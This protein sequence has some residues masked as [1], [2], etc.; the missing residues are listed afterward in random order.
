MSVRN[1]F[2]FDL[3]EP[4]VIPLIDDPPIGL[5]GLDIGAE[6][7]IINEEASDHDENGVNVDGEEQERIANDNFLD[8]NGPGR[9]DSMACLS[10]TRHRL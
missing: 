9:G 3:I 8:D 7:D 6:V 2:H 10:F 1:N 4:P 5:F